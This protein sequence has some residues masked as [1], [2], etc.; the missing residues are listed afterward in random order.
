MLLRFSY[1]PSV[2]WCIYLWVTRNSFKFEERR[3]SNNCCRREYLYLSLGWCFFLR[4]VSLYLVK[5]PPGNAIEK[6]F[7][8]NYFKIVL[9][10]FQKVSKCQVD[11]DT[12]L[13]SKTIIK[14]T[15]RFLCKSSLLRSYIRSICRIAW[16]CRKH[17][18]NM[19]P[20]QEIYTVNAEIII[21]LLLRE[22]IDWKFLTD[23]L[24]MSSTK[25][26][27]MK[28]MLKIPAC[29]IFTILEWV[30]PPWVLQCNSTAARSADYL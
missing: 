11:N 2:A 22:K 29:V 25:Q 4:A 21:L 30:S 27:P 28:L 1:N 24:R 9:P 10:E 19:T 15:D 16:N 7:Q 20:V 6:C 8:V 3:S 23:G 5:H 14:N 17:S 13:W 26:V 18:L 12:V